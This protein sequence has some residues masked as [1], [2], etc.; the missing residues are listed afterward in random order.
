MISMSSLW[1][2][3][4]DQIPHISFEDNFFQ[5]YFRYARMTSF[6]ISKLDFSATMSNINAQFAPWNKGTKFCIIQASK[7]C[8]KV[9]PVCANDVIDIFKVKFLGCYKQYLCAVCASEY[10]TQFCT[11]HAATT[12]L[13][14][15]RYARMKSLKFQSLISLLL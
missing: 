3:V 11:Y 6:K 7:T 15:F 4:Q 13:K 5:K 14:Y 12:F 8:S 1:Q 9:L 10:W 2:E